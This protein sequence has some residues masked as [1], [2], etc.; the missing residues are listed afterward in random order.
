MEN[1]K[2]SEEMLSLIKKNGYLGYHKYLEGKT[3]EN[4]IKSLEEI[5]KIILAGKDLDSL[6]RIRKIYMEDVKR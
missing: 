4:L 6:K 5:V 3:D 2:R 1:N